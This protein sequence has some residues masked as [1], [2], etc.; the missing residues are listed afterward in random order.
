M[1]SRHC[2]DIAPFNIWSDEKGNYVPLKPNFLWVA[3][4]YKARNIDWVQPFWIVATER[5][6]LPNHDGKITLTIGGAPVIF[7][8]EATF[9]T[10]YH[11]GIPRANALIYVNPSLISMPD[12]ISHLLQAKPWTS[13]TRQEAELIFNTLKPRCS[14]IAMNFVFRELIIELANNGRTYAKASLPSRVGGWSVSYHHN[15]GD[16]A[17]WDTKLP[18]ARKREVSPFSQKVPSIFGDMTNYRIVDEGVLGPGIRVAGQTKFSSAGIRIRKG[19]EVRMT[20]AQHSFED[21]DYVYHPDII[22]GTQIAE[23]TTRYPGQDL[24]LAKI[25][26]GVLFNNTMIF[27]SP[28]PTKLLIGD[29]IG[30]NR[31]WFFCD[32]CT[33]GVIAMKFGG[34]RFARNADDEITLF[35]EFQPASVWYGLAPTGGAQDIRDG[36]CGAPIVHE[37]D[38]AVAGFFQYIDDSGFCFSPHLD[39]LIDDEWECY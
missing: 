10:G 11:P 37:S 16:A 32:S 12:P 13:P 15:V 20:L 38:G 39:K 25:A 2:L 9:K 24:A 19:T 23:I 34:I 5:P 1:G 28:I 14:I 22:S 36:I 31:E 21:D 29:A 4:T 6:S 35:S 30:M 18:S 7:I 33:T 3:H 17:F 8:S 27:E 26:P